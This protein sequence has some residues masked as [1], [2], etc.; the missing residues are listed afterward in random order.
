MKSLFLLIAATLGTLAT[1]RVH[2]FGLPHHQQQHILSSSGVTT[3]KHQL[4][5]PRRSDRPVVVPFV[6][7]AAEIL[8]Q[9][10][11]GAPMTKATT[12]MPPIYNDRELYRVQSL[13]GID[14]LNDEYA[15]YAGNLIVDDK[16]STQFFV[17]FE[18]RGEATTDDLVVWFNGGPGGSSLFGLFVENGPLVFD[19]AS[20][21]LVHNPYGW[22]K[23]GNAL[24]VENPAGVGF[25]TFTDPANVVKTN[26][27]VG[28]QFW[29]FAQQF[30]RIFE[31]PHRST[32]RLTKPVAFRWWITGESFA[33][34]YIPY[35]ARAVLDHN[36]QLQKTESRLDLRGVAIGNGAFE[37]PYSEPASW[38][39]YLVTEGIARDQDRIRELQLFRDACITERFDSDRYER[40]DLPGCQAIE[41]RLFNQSY[42][43]ALSEGKH[44]LPTNF[45][46]RVTECGAAD[47][48][49]AAAGMVATFLNSPRA[50]AALHATPADGPPRP[51]NFF[52]APVYDALNGNGDAPSADL[53][54][55]LVKEK[56]RVLLYV[57]DRDFICP[58]PGT[59]RMLDEYLA[60][61]WGRFGHVRRGF[62]DQTWREFG[63]GIDKTGPFGLT[64]SA[65]GLTYMRVLNAGHMVPFNDGPGSLAMVEAFVQGDL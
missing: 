52:S 6:P 53:L 32:A 59:E 22:H 24:F 34:M 8:A 26:K 43:L 9:F 54:P 61:G 25:S 1:T 21:S 45:D 36:R 10:R 56:V 38:V 18:R 13:P 28:E 41:A 20:N 64:K 49:D 7:N 15:T 11:A 58:Y 31:G 50:A 35:M 63:T 46:V 42:F 14:L 4:S 57:G 39:D 51:W 65:R 37:S 5:G 40:G 47:P 29:Q 3:H 12:G 19:T 44:C 16:N 17:Y 48:T 60:W 2:G 27:D 30:T 23:A 62:G 55:G 33:G